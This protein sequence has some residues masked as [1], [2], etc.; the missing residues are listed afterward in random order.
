[1]NKKEL[2]QKEKQAEQRL[3][4]FLEKLNLILAEYPDL[5]F[6][7]DDPYCGVWANIMGDD[8]KCLASHPL[9]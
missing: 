2:T 7:S 3:K 8:G 5:V 6:E 9:P 4:M 1:M